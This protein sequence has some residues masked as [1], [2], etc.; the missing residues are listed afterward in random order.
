M[1]LLNPECG[2]FIGSQEGSAARLATEG[3]EP[4]WLRGG[5][6]QVRTR[7]PWLSL[8]KSLVGHRPAPGGQ[9]A[10][11]SGLFSGGTPM[12]IKEYKAKA[13]RTA[14]HALSSREALANWSLGLGG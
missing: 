12:N 11:H 5:P 4:G 9:R 14:N 3:P 10:A 6:C 1:I 8:F 2:H 13:R 7:L